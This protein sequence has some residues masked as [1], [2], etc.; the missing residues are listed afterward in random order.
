MLN[1]FQHLNFEMRGYIYILGNNNLVLYIGVSSNLIKRIYEHKQ[2][3]IE[4]FTKKYKLH[5]LLY[6]EVLESIGE[7]IKREKQLKNWHRNWK[8]NLIKTSNPTFKDLYSEI[9]RS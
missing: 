6:Y 5:K 8:L 1:L 4:G 7:A 3:F 9:I 2:E